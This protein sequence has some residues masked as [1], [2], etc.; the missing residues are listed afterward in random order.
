MGKLV[1][2]TTNINA[3]LKKA[4]TLHCQRNGL[5]IQSFIEMAI[6]EQLEDEIDLQAVRDRKNEDEI[7]LADVLKKIKR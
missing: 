7:S 5:K 4:L 3:E 2:L 1:S 6:L